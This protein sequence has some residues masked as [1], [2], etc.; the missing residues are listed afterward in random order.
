MDSIAI[1]IDTANPYALTRLVDLLT[2]AA[3]GSDES[4]N[5]HTTRIT[6]HH[7]GTMKWSAEQTCRTSR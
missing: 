1:A 2:P 7:G 3:I 5:L 6:G 4:G